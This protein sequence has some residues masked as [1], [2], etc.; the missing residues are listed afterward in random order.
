MFRITKLTVSN[1]QVPFVTTIVSLFVFFC[2]TAESAQAQESQSGSAT[3]ITPWVVYVGTTPHPVQVKPVIVSGARVFMSLDVIRALDGRLSFDSSGKLISA[4]ISNSKIEISVKS[5]NASLNEM[6]ISSDLLLEIDDKWYLDSSLWNELGYKP[7]W[8]PNYR[9]WQVVGK[10]SRFTYK[11]DTRDLVISSILPVNVVSDQSFSEKTIELTIQ[12]SFVDKDE[13]LHFSNPS[14]ESVSVS[15]NALTN[16]TKIEIKQNETT[17]FR[18]YTDPTKG[19]I[20]VN[21]RN[22]FQLVDFEPTSSS[23]IRLKI[24]FAKPTDVKVM[25]LSNP[26]RLV[27]DFLDCIY[28]DAS[29]RID[30]NYGHVSAVRIGQFSEPPAP[31]IVRVVVDLTSKVGYRII[32]SIE[33]DSYYVQFIDKKPGKYAIA[34]DAGHGGSDPGALSP[35]SDTTEKAL[36][37]DIARRVRDILEDKGQKVIMTRDGDYFISLSERADLANALLPM[38]FVSIHNNSIESPDIKG[39]MTF[40]YSGSIEGKKLATYIQSGIALSTGA[41]NKGV[42][43]A[44]FY[45]LRETVVPA[46]LVECGFLT[47]QEEEASLRDLDYRNRIALGIANGILDYCAHINENS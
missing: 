36:N 45:V 14:C 47:N 35:F 38:F 2:L 3:D 29:K 17:G 44:N 46:A 12:N 26:S 23:E 27:L 28:P 10:L 22:H 21:F 24:R 18:V 31:Y 25:E 1:A 9:A 20:R 16:S 5:R 39:V 37:L 32:P 41:V 19:I 15:Y 30:I 42:R 34:I 43:T 7:I 33:K 40:H 8:H 4:E 11:D 13:L 6:N